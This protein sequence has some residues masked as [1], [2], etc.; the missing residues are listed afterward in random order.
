MTPMKMPDHIWNFLPPA[1]KKSKKDTPVVSPVVRT[2]VSVPIGGKSASP[3]TASENSEKA[4]G[5]RLMV[6]K[7]GRKANLSQKGSQANSDSL[8]PPASML[9]KL[10][11]SLQLNPLQRIK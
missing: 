10:Q 7:G 11:Q 1:I 4:K 9:R 3:E 2:T 5:E 6:G 8:V